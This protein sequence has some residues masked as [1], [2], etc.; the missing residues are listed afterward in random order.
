[1]A[2]VYTKADVDSLLATINTLIGTK[3]TTSSVTTLSSTV[4][5]LTAASVGALPQTPASG[6]TPGGYLGMLTALPASAPAAGYFCIV[7]P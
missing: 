7:A 6:A 5:S 3:A 1:M 2:T 4:S